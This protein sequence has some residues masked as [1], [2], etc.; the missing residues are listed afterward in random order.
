MLRSRLPRMRKPAGPAVAVAWPIAAAF[1]IAVVTWQ[2]STLRATTGL[3]PSWIAGLHLVRSSGIDF[4]S[5]FTWTYGPLGFLAFP[6][7]VTG[8]TLAAAFAFVFLAQ[9]AFCYLLLR[10]AAAAFAAPVA[11][12]LVYLVVALPVAHADLLL[13]VVFLLALWAL[14]QPMNLMARWFPIAAGVL[15]GAAA[16]M[17][18]NTGAAAIGIALVTSWA[19]QPSTRRWLA[20]IPA[21]L[22]TFVVLWIATGNSLTGVP[23]WLR[24]SASIVAGYSPAMQDEQAGLR[25]EYLVAGILVALLAVVVGAQI[26]S[27]ERRR[28]IGATLVMLAFVFTYFKEGF[29]RHDTDHSPY[30]FAAMAIGFL[31]VSVRDRAR[32]AAAGG[33]LVSLGAVAVTIGLHFAPIG[34]MRHVFRQAGDVAGSTKRHQLVASSAA[35]ERQDYGVPRRL[36]AQLRGKTVH[37][38]PVETAA[39]GAYHLRWRPLPIPQSYSAYTA[40][41]DTRNADFLA[42]RGAP[43]R[44]LRQ[45]TQV[46]VNGRNR[47]L[48][49]PAAF[50][51][52][53]CNYTQTGASQVWQVLAHT[54]PRCD[55]ERQVGSA[56]VTSGEQVSVPQAGPDDVLIARIHLHNPVL[57]QIVGFAYKPHTPKISLGGG[58]FVPLV[59]ATAGDGIVL[60]VP[61]S[62]GF[63]P[64]FDGATDW[65]TV[66]VRT[67]SGSAR[68]DFYAIRI[69]GR[70]ATPFGESPHGPLP[71]YT[72]EEI[73][74][75]EHIRNPAGRISPVGAG[76]GFL[77]AAYLVGDRFAFGGWAADANTGVAASRIL[78]FVAGKLVFT[79]HPNVDR[80]DVAAAFDRQSLRHTGFDVLLRRDQVMAGA[81]PRNVR[82]FA[83]VDDRV[84]ELTY[85][86][87]DPWHP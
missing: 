37:V 22:V 2:T 84:L 19:I 59:L 49:A 86:S 16:L 73:R 71:R 30:F 87:D 51:A 15:A 5:D 10:R 64:R 40:T 36:L 60:R 20:V 45:N 55:G 1:G 48:E 81:A 25:W 23:G 62:A 50:R 26:A 77:D 29:V 17:K 76:G 74:G 54:G 57:N 67:L 44:I 31:A 24:L 70:A 8:S 3:D 32:W 53:L 14:G 42:S 65:R 18:T 11:I 85:P 27:W 35:L 52:L 58:P 56:T 34:S 43:E 6:L 7:A 9:L 39:I 83:L 21:I 80:P 41:L 12:A 82:V 28:R 72:L 78:V 69:R 66:A 75:H 68:V 79:G 47:E 61:P 33:V 46:A 38:D 63:D 13:V 4:G